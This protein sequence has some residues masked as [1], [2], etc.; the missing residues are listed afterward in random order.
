MSLPGVLCLDAAGLVCCNYILGRAGKLI[1][2]AF[3]P[4]PPPAEGQE[5]GWSCGRAEGETL[6]GRLTKGDG[7]V[8]GGNVRFGLLSGRSL[9]ARPRCCRHEES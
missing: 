9:F 8:A 1:G 3:R 7:V 5:R 4:L 2:R 6:T